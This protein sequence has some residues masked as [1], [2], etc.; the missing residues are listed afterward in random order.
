HG[1]LQVIIVQQTGER[2]WRNRVEA[3]DQERVLLSDGG[4]GP[5]PGAQQPAQVVWLAGAMIENVGVRQ[6]ESF[7][8]FYWLLVQPAKG[9]VYGWWQALHAGCAGWQVLR[10]EQPCSA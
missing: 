1:L 9:R 4:S 2:G 7:I 6:L 3:G 10:P 5:F 8:N